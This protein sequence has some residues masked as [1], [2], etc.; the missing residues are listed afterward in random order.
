MVWLV[1]HARKVRDLYSTPTFVYDETSL[2]QNATECLNFPAPY[3]LTVRYAMKANSNAIIL[4]I[5][6]Q[7][8]LHIDA[9][10]GYEAERAMRAGI[11]PEK[12]CIS[13]Q[14][15]EPS[16]QK[17]VERGV[18]VDACS[19]HQLEMLG[20]LC[21]GAEVSFCGPPPIMRALF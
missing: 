10:S 3:G 2:R 20:K 9:A 18:H 1:Q 8:G 15:L 4:R 11:D 12:I 16:I 13:S 5:F 6:E 17:L 19:L 7:M 21:P 14:E